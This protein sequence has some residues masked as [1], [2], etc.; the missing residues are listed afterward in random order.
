MKNWW[1]SGI[2]LCAVALVLGALYLKSKP[3]EFWGDYA[4]KIVLGLS[5]LAFV[6]YLN[7]RID[8]KGKPLIFLGAFSYE[9]YLIHEA[10]FPIIDRMNTPLSSG[11]FILLC[12]SVS[13]VCAAVVHYIAKG[14]LRLWQ[15]LPWLGIPD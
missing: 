10:I 8:L 7:T 5:I 9:V 6:L 13:V 1:L 2:L 12:M 15:R 3:I 14:L 11:W 4:L